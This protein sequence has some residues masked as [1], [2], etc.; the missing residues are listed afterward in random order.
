MNKLI[1]RVIEVLGSD[2]GS[3]YILPVVVTDQWVLRPIRRDL[4]PISKWLSSS[5]TNFATAFSATLWNGLIPKGGF[6]LGA[7]GELAGFMPGE[8]RCGRW[9]WMEIIKPGDV[10]SYK[11]DLI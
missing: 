8:F 2:A 6:V 3:R 7:N 5:N 4:S 1:P 11:R 10:F 9:E